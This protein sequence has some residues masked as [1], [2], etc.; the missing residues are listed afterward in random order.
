M[1]DINTLAQYAIIFLGKSNPEIDE[2][3]HQLNLSGSFNNGKRGGDVAREG[4]SRFPPT[5]GRMWT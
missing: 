5:S 2:V 4:D 1:A 3:L